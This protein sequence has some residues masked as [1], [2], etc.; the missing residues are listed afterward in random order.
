[1]KSCKLSN[2]SIKSGILKNLIANRFI[3]GK[4]D[5]IFLQKSFTS[6]STSTY[7]GVNLMALKIKSQQI[8]FLSRFISYFKAFRQKD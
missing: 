5:F 7:L 8:S 4:T 3:P 1:M 2:P 6:R